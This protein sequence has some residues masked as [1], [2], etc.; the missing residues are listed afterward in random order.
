MSVMGCICAEHIAIAATC[1]GELKHPN[2]G[3]IGIL[4]VVVPFGLRPDRVVELEHEAHGRLIRRRTIVEGIQK[5]K[6]LLL[7][8]P[9]GFTGGMEFQV[10]VDGDSDPVVLSQP[11]LD[12]DNVTPEAVTPTYS[13]ESRK[14]GICKEEVDS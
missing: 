4:N 2:A 13:T 5:S 3:P 9:R 8:V 6:H 12:Y 14:L 1:T 11:T 7:I 10:S